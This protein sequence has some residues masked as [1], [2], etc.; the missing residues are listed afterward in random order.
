MLC[1]GLFNHIINSHNF[2]SFLGISGWLPLRL[3][4]DMLWN[5]T[6]N[7]SGGP[8]KNLEM[9]L[10]NEMLNKEFRGN[11]EIRTARFFKEERIHINS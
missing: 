11:K 2:I 9:D 1:N 8:G 10:V 7:L 5:R 3:Q 4:K 6:V